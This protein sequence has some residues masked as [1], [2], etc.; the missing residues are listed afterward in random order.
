MDVIPKYPLRW[1]HGIFND[2][3]YFSNELL[4]NFCTHDSILSRDII[5]SSLNSQIHK[6]NIE[7]YL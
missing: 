7:L 3:D 5:S 4:S 1:Y 6:V 2:D